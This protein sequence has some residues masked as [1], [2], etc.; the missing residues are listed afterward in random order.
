VTLLHQCSLFLLLTYHS[1]QRLANLL[2]RHVPHTPGTPK[3]GNLMATSDK[4]D[5]LIILDRRVDIITPLLTQLTYEGLIDETIGIRNCK[6]LHR[7]PHRKHLMSSLNLSAHVEL[8]ISLLSP[9]APPAPSTS[10]GP[11]VPPQTPSPS[12]P[13][14]AKE[15]KKKHHLATMMDPLFAELRDLN[16]ASVGKRLNRVA[17]RLDEDYKVVLDSPSC[18]NSFELTTYAG[19]TPS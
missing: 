17:H 7:A 12:A 1:S 2:A 3:L 15:K 18:F 11:S 8:P 4:L 9:P 13:A 5:C 19:S 16:F 6:Y 10:A 14:L